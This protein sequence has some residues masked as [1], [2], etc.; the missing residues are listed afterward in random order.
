MKYYLYSLLDSFLY[1]VGKNVIK[2][3]EDTNIIQNRYKR[4]LTLQGLCPKITSI[5]DLFYAYEKQDGKVLYD[6]I[7]DEVMNDFIS[8]LDS[9]LWINI[10]ILGSELKKFR[11]A[12]FDFYY[13]MLKDV[14]DRRIL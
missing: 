10:K 12:C 9:N 1:F 11:L 5:K 2:Y 8:W 14:L 13:K 7:N 4:S 3:F 6:V